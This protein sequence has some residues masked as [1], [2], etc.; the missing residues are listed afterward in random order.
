VYPT[1]I[2]ERPT[3]AQCKEGDPNHKQN[4]SN[5]TEEISHSDCSSPSDS[6]PISLLRTAMAPSTL[7]EEE[8]NVGGVRGA[9]SH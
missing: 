7:E 4:F 6:K 5:H 9:K 3:G 8:G 1:S 2:F